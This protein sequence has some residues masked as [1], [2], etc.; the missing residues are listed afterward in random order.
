MGKLGKI[1]V[2]LVLSLILSVTLFTSSAFAQHMSSSS[3]S[4]TIL[5]GPLTSEILV[6]PDPTSQSLEP[7]PSTNQQTNN[8]PA[9]DQQVSQG[10]DN[11]N[12]PNSCQHTTKCTHV[13]R[14]AWGWMFICQGW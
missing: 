2:T 14:G 6:K 5:A 1:G 7:Q 11:C 12:W 10:K 13:F 4:S 8:P 3:N 9:N